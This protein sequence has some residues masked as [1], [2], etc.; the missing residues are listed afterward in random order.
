MA[1]DPYFYNG[2]PVAPPEAWLFARDDTYFVN[3]GEGVFKSATQDWTFIED[4]PPLYFSHKEGDSTSIFCDS[5]GNEYVVRLRTAYEKFDES[6]K[7]SK[8]NYRKVK[9]DNGS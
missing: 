6:D 5:A 2:G 1:S 4:E 3:G 9:L 7:L 8:A